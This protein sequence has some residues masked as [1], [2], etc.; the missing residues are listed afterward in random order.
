MPGKHPEVARVP[1]EKVQ[2]PAPHRTQGTPGTRPQGCHMRGSRMQEK[3]S[4]ENGGETQFV[5]L[6][7]PRFPLNDYSQ[8]P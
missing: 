6:G 1:T 8:A 2:G 4:M 5:S 7:T 3:Q